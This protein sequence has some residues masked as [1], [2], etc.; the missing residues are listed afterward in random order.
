MGY[1]LWITLFVTFLAIVG[2]GWD[3]FFNGV[4]KGA[5]KLGITQ[6]VEN[7]TKNAQDSIKEIVSESSKDIINNLAEEK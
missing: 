1:V 7:I 3:N 2:L 4:L 5:D 6:T